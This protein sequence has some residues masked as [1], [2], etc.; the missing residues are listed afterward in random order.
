MQKLDN[1]GLP[2]ILYC[3]TFNV[4]AVTGIDENCWVFS[5]ELL[6]ACFVCKRDEL[7]T[8]P[9]IISLSYVDLFTCLLLIILFLFII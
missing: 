5:L 7:Y 1:S 6:C 9:G 4:L 2:L 8:Y 3:F